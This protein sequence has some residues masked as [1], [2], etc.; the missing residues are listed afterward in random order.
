MAINCGTKASV[1]VRQAASTCSFKSSESWII[2]NPI[3]QRIKTK[4]EAAG[5]PLKEWDI[6]INRGILTGYNE[7]FIIDRR[8]KDELIQQDP[9]SAEI[10]RPILRGRD[11]KRYSYEFA[12]IYLIATFPSLKIDIE[13]Y[14]AVKQHLLSFGYDRLKQTGEQGARKK[15]S[16]KWFET[17]DSIGY[18]DDFS[19]QKLLWAETMR[20]HR[21][22]AINFPRFGFEANG[23]YITDK[24]CFF[25]TGSH[26]KFILGVL[27][28]N[29]GRY[30]C[31]QYVSILD[32][33]GYLMQK[34]Y[35]EKIPIAP[36]SSR[37]EKAVECEA[38]DRKDDEINNIVYELY[39][40]T[41][42]EIKFVESSQNL[43]LQR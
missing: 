29:V 43:P 26:L 25:A 36:Y 32:D 21:S 14:P 39:N 41:Q 17:Q 1:F 42:D 35:L 7:A 19:K 12:D 38:N 10:I 33:G 13:K 8:K 6:N 40:L 37:L 23:Q 15:T 34:I 16:N 28:S 2:L 18:W 20:I 30:L 11:I 4:I 9:K 5:K 24:T 27:N 3:E 22:D 31:S